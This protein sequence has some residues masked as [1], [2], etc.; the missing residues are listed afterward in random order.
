MVYEIR[1]RILELKLQLAREMLANSIDTEDVQY[2]S[3]L[4]VG[5][6]QALAVYQGR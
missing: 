5:Y 4:V 2:Y 3:G 6:D 1:E